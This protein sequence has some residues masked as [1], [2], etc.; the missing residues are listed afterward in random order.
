MLNTFIIYSHLFKIILQKLQAM[1]YWRNGDSV[2]VLNDLHLE[3]RGAWAQDVH[4]ALIN[5]DLFIFSYIISFYLIIQ[6]ICSSRV[7]T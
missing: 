4:K 6:G 5:F 7:R 3:P 2:V 1:S